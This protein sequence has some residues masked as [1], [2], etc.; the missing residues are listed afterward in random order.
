MAVVPTVIETSVAPAVSLAGDRWLLARAVADGRPCLRVH[1]WSGTVLRLGRYH[2]RLVADAVVRRLSGGR[3]VPAG[4]GFVNVSLALPHRSAIASDDPHALTGEQVLN[5]AVRGVLGGLELL[6]IDPTY[7]GRDL[8]TVRGKAIA[9]ISLAV[10]EGGATLVEAS[11]AVERDLAL[12]GPLADRIDPAG[13]VP[14][15]LWQDDE[16]TSVAREGG[17]TSGRE[18]AAAIVE[19]YRRR[20]GWQVDPVAPPSAESLGGAAALDEPDEPASWARRPSLLGTLMASVR[21]GAHGRIARV[22][23]AGDLIAPVSTVMAIERCVEGEALRRELLIHHILTAL[24][25]DAHFLL[26]ARPEEVAD[27]VMAGGML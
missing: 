21:L 22:R 16:V 12:L 17:A 8:V 4:A 23:L 7:P 18:V 27:V 15:R 11:V 26:G 10:E 5:R 13:A 19:G 2:P 25:D 1:V 3:A 6:G 14:V 9:W 20:L 24:A